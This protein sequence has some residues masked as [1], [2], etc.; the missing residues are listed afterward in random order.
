MNN[1]AM[2]SAAILVQRTALGLQQLSISEDCTEDPAGK[3]EATHATNFSDIPEELQESILQRV[4]RL[5]NRTMAVCKC[6]SESWMDYCLTLTFSGSFRSG[7]HPTK[8]A[9]EENSLY[10]KGHEH[11]HAII[12]LQATNV[13]LVVRTKGRKHRGGFSI[14]FRDGTG[15]PC[16]WVH[17]LSTPCNSSPLVAA[18]GPFS[19]TP[20][21][22]TSIEALGVEVNFQTSGRKHQGTV[23]LMVGE[24]PEEGL[25][26]EPACAVCTEHG[27]FVWV[28][29]Q[30]DENVLLMDSVIESKFMYHKLNG[31]LY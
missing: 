7:H 29:D 24:N 10:Y 26:D 16:S 20:K 2:K 21:S 23:T 6:V 12:R 31:W 5:D 19:E 8:D 1:S 9:D 18:V 30:F 3:A 13:F 14:H 15:R 27:S 17:W 11:F 28:L 25:K 22:E 4:F